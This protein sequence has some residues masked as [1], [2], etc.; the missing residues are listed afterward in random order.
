[1]EAW[2]LLRQIVSGL[3]ISYATLEK[4]DLILEAFAGGCADFSA[5]SQ[6]ES[7]KRLQAVK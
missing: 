2:Y 3:P 7:N 5:C 1:L 4:G 6:S